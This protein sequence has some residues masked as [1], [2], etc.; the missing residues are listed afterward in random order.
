MIKIVKT[1]ILHQRVIRE[2]G[3]D[4]YI[5]YIKIEQGWDAKW[6]YWNHKEKSLSLTPPWEYERNSGHEKFYFS[7]DDKENVIKEFELLTNYT[8]SKRI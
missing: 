7:Q 1:A 5:I 4:D 3:F 2:V 6:V 8:I